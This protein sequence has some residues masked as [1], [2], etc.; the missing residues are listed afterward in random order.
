MV[1]ESVEVEYFANNPS[2]VDEADETRS[3]TVLVGASEI[4]PREF[5]AESSNVFPKL[6]PPS[7]VAHALPEAWMTPALVTC[8]QLVTVFP[9]FET[10]RS[11]VEAVPS[12]RNALVEA[13]PVTEKYEDVALVEVEYFELRKLR[14]EDADGTRRPTRVE[15]GVKYILSVEFTT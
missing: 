15:V 12:T 13:N 14:V 9:R 10:V 7:A 3:P 11:E 2:N 4:W 1:V 6:A 5:A 8:T